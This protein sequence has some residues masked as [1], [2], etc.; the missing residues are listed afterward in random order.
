VTKPKTRKVGRERF[1]ASRSL[2]PGTGHSSSILSG[3]HTKYHWC[4]FS[5]DE[6]CRG[7]TKQHHPDFQ[8]ELRGLGLDFG[9]SIIATAILD[10]LLHHSTTINIRGESYRLK[11][12][13][14][15][16]LVPSKGQDGSAA[17]VSLASASVP[18]KTRQKTAL[19]PHYIRG[20]GGPFMNFRGGEFSSGVD[21][22]RIE[23]HRLTV[24]SQVIGGRF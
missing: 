19:G 22:P 24:I 13:R 11:E 17:S 1:K 6:L 12:R 7:E 8:Q 5:A 20:Q 21:T 15:A 10:R 4:V 3:Q 14:K 9:D 2:N 16:G 23:Q 18:P